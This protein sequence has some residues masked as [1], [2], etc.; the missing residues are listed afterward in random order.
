MTWV[1]IAL[2]VLR[3]VPWFG[4]LVDRWQGRKQGRKEQRLDSLEATKEQA[5]DANRI[6][7]DVRRLDDDSLYAELHGRPRDNG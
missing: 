4:R 7:E 5:S 1:S 3:F 6:D 2:A